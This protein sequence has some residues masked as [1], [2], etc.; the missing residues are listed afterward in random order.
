MLQLTHTPKKNTFFIHALFFCIFL[1]LPAW[2]GVL[3]K[4]LAPPA[5][6]A[7]ASEQNEDEFETM[8][9][10]MLE[11]VKE[12]GMVQ[13]A[14]PALTSPLF[15]TV[16]DAAL[17]MD[18][19]E[20][21]F[22]AFFFPD[23]IPRIYPQRIMV[24]HEVVNEVLG[25]GT[26]SITYSPLTGSLAAYSGTLG[27][28]N[29]GFGVTGLLLDN[30]TVLYDFYSRS[31]WA[32]LPGLCFDG[33]LKGR[34]LRRLPV[35]W[36]TWERAKATYPNARVLSSS[37]RFKRDYGRDPYGNYMVPGSYYDTGPVVYSLNHIDKRLPLKHPILGVE[38]DG[39]YAA[40]DKKAARQ[41]GVINFTLGVTPLVAAYDPVLD[42]IRLF[43]RS[44]D[45][46]TLFFE[47]ADGKMVD[48][49]TRTEWSREGTGELGY[50]RGKQL[51]PVIGV[52]S[53]WFAWANFYPG[54]RIIP[55][56]SF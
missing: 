49:E 11:R 7:P 30:N 39:L 40:V 47:W 53:M 20:A 37:T 15:V 9:K 50:F 2:S 8:L 6:A 33:P 36:T 51:V 28:F 23:G 19:R 16:G 24:W 22:I 46:R 14:I 34:K 5:L 1:I 27:R 29:L 12:T 54:T 35:F 43:K 10:N 55:G 4:E 42:T 21:V 45:D 38:Q 17:S 56:H 41:A 32:Q 52:D 3:F 13:D 31:K 25:N 18:A 48:R 26:C 44:F